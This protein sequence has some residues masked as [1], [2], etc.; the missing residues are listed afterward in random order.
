VL[1]SAASPQPACG[2]ANCP[3]CENCQD[4]QFL[5]FQAEVAGATAKIKED[6]DLIRVGQAQIASLHQ[7]IGAASARVRDNN[8][9]FSYANHL[10]VG[11][12]NHRTV[13]CV[14][15]TITSRSD[16]AYDWEDVRHEPC[17]QCLACGK[18]DFISW[19]DYNE[20]RRS[21]VVDVESLGSKRKRSDGSS[22]S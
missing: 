5:E 2:I 22:R 10:L 21:E 3:G 4:R 11:R 19:R 1:N 13:L 20:A 7:D 18:Q 17:R 9:H 12:C 16:N 8:A 15:K 14:A 6:E